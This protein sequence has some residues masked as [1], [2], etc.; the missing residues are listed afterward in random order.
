MRNLALSRTA[1][2]PVLFFVACAPA[3]DPGPPVEETEATVRAVS[4][5]MIENEMARNFEVVGSFYAPDA[6]FQA[7]NTPLISG[8]QDILAAYREFFDTFLDMEA[9]VSEVVASE[10]GDLAFE[11]GTNRVVVDS[12]EGPVEL[13]GKYSRGWQKM[14]GT[15]QILIQTYSADTVPPA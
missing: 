3:A 8:R 15:W 6:L 12:E 7:A 4:E 10:S 2:L 1:L 14:D 9:E 13:I 11:W 5:E